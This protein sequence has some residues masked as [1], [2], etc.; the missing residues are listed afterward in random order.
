[1]IGVPKIERVAEG[2]SNTHS[3]RVR[4]G[5]TDA[6]GI[7]YYANYYR[8]FEGG[9]A[10]LMR[11]AGLPY[12]SVVDKGLFLPVV[13]SWCKYHRSARYDDLLTITSWVH[14]VRAATVIIA[15]QV[16]LDDTLLAEGGARLACVN[17]EGRARRLPPEIR[18]FHERK[19]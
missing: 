15:H 14:E 16:H 6:A 4:F 9:R 7:V 2:W 13:E 18:S 19:R 10:E 11:A 17:Q 3:Y 5:D 8:L 12:Y 1:M